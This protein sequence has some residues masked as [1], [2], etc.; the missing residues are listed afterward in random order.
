MNRFAR[1]LS[2]KRASQPEAGCAQWRVGSIDDDGMRYGSITN[3]LTSNTIATPPTAV[4]IQ[5]PVT[6]IG[7][8]RPRVRRSTGFREWR[9]GGGAGAGGASNVLAY[10]S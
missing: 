4:T 9:R 3:A 2:E 10:S 1:T 6:R 5:S 7:S 8:G